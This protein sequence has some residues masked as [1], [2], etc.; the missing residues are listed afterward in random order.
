MAVRIDMSCL[1]PKGKGYC[2]KFPNLHSLQWAAKARR[3]N[4][5]TAACKLLPNTASLCSD[6][7]RSA[8]FD[9]RISFEIKQGYA[10]T[11]EFATVDIVEKWPKMNLPYI[12]GLAQKVADM[13]SSQIR[14]NFAFIDTGSADA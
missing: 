13:E 5:L 8:I 9:A 4:F 7:S 6:T 3:K 11:F 1:P 2:M 14:I 10:I 12:P